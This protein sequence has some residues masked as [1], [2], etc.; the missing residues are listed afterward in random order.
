MDCGCRHCHSK[1]L[2]KVVSPC[3]LKL[4]NGTSIQVPFKNLNTSNFNKF[5][6]I[7]CSDEANNNVFSQFSSILGGQGNTVIGINA[8]C[9]GGVN[10]FSG[11]E[12][13]TTQGN[14]TRATGASSHTEGNLTTALS[15]NTHAEGIGTIAFA[16]AAHAEGSTTSAFGQ[17]SHA[18]GSGVLAFGGIS[19]AEGLVTSATGTVSHAE[20]N[21][22][23]AFGTGSHA[24]GALTSASGEAAHSEGEFTT[25][26]GGQS[27]S[28]GSSTTASGSVSHAEGSSTIADEF[29]A[30]AE[31]RTTISSGVASHSEGISTTASGEASHAEGTS[32]TAFGTSSHAGGNLAEAAHDRSYVISGGSTTVSSLLIESYTAKYPGGFRVFTADDESTGATMAAGQGSWTAISLRSVKDV[33]EEYVDGDEILDMISEWQISKWKYITDKSNSAHISPFSDEF[34]ELELGADPDGIQML[35]LAGVLY[36]CVQSLHNTNKKLIKDVEALKMNL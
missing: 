6:I 34:R 13:S 24:E 35:D 9:L 15:S 8:T 12:N 11:G 26:S 31:G 27:H 22:T 18:E 17:L 19:H 32:T 30:H 25:A 36:A 28:E 10:N 21:N 16:T 5:R 33:I 20:G 29:S 14:G 23:T 7:P 2:P 1:C 4:K 3:L